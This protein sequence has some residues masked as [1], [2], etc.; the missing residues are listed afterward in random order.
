MS[1]ELT[2]NQ[3]ATILNQI[4]KQATGE[5]SIIATNYDFISVGQKVLKTGYDNTLSAISQVLTKTQFS[6]R[7]YT[8]KFK[9]ITVTNQQF[10]NITR[11]LSI[12]DTEFVEEDS[13]K[14]VDG[15]AIDQWIVRKPNVLQLN[16]YGQNVWSDYITIFKHQLD[17]AFTSAEEFGRFITM[18]MQNMSD[19]MEQSREA[20]ARSVVA[21]YIA[22]KSEA[23]NG[24]IHLLTEYNDLTGLSLTKADLY[25]PENYKDFM[26]WVDSR[27]NTLASLM[28]ERSELFHINVTDN[29]VKRHT[30][31][32]KLNMYL[33]APQ[34]YGVESRVL[35]D[36][37]HDNY[38]TLAKNEVVNYW[39]S[40]ESPDE[41]KADAVYL[42]DDGTL[43]TSVA[44]VE[45]TDVF[46]VMFDEEALGVT[47]VNQWM[48][49]TPMNA[50][51]GYYNLWYHENKRFWTDYTENGIV[52]LLD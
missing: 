21:N 25:K 48:Q 34:K 7:P 28:T 8:A 40:I 14:L 6:I 49:Q 27:I 23:D 16:Y 37:Y 10:G 32:N 26:Q 19:K 33:Y 43:Q 35:A 11:K 30:P 42:L 46:G 20:L 9:G 44:T 13:E 38:L 1:N 45:L 22:G 51:G 52:L 29:P 4:Q 36:T 47:Y 15:E 12:S 24:V 31:M 5:T 50:R 2:R 3:L 39:Q 41:I 17:T 18:I